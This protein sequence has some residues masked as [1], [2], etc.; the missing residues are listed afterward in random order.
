[1]EQASPKPPINQPK[2]WSVLK[3]VLGVLVVLS[4]FNR[5]AQGEKLFRWE[6]GKVGE[7]LGYNIAT[8]VFIILAI[9]LIVSGIRERSKTN[10]SAN[11]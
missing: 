10:N 8:I 2:K 9:W 3:I 5:I 7:N 6:E 1:M 11:N 4:Y